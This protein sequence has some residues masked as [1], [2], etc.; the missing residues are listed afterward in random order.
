MRKWWPLVAVCTG[1]FMLL[2]DVTIVTVA[3][4]DMARGLH[5]SFSALEWVMDIY[6]LVLAAL[7]LGAGS[8]ADLAG[9]RLVYVGGLVVFA[10]SS[11][12][13]GLAPDA[14]VLIA[15]RGVQGLGAA[16]MFATNLALMNNV[17]QG[18]DRGI[19]F[20][21]WGAVNG[22]AAATGP[23]LGGLLTQWFGW[24]SIFLVNLP[25][26]VFAVAV[27]MRT[28]TES[29]NPH[30]R[31]LDMGGLVTFT[32]AA[33]A[34][35][36]ALIRAGD[37]G[38]GSSSTLG[39]LAL[40]LVSLAVFVVIEAR[41]KAPMLDLALFRS[42]A[43]TA[44]M[45]GGLLLTASAF[46]FMTFT[47][48][49]LQSVLGLSSIK[50]G[51][52][53]LPLC[54]ASFLVAAI[55]GRFLHGV[56]PRWT[57]GF[58]LLLIGAGGLAQSFLSAGSG[59]AALVPGLV[60]T[61]V[62]VGAATPM[63]ASAAMAAV[64]MTRAGMAG[65][66]LN[67]FRQLGMALGIAV[68]GGVFRNGLEGSLSGTPANGTAGAL[69]GGQA[70]MVIGHTPPARRPVVEHAVRAAFAHGLDQTYV[71]AGCTGLAAGLM[72]LALVRTTRSPA[73]PEPARTTPAPASA[74]AEAR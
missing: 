23:I 41:G 21:V 36:Y 67:T 50:A 2:V 53:L 57:V 43:F 27:T 56:S 4:P 25:V 22:A 45:V 70:R 46:S 8:L 51:L 15:A 47:S 32:I 30:A 12:A 14:G 61:G 65:S 52:V 73:P 72:V 55:G 1:A 66:T 68:L 64:P 63:L 29:R 9:R 31:G 59:W 44:I 38:W 48:L 17:Y 62:G 16:A 6:A 49:W 28:V 54:A 60:V 13:C 69:A 34:V 11:L 7:L 37:A 26:S 74:S 42:P 58:G 24:Q 39:L 5:T 33:G 19:A 3:I 71:V 35:T 18:R 10:L 20:G 40:G